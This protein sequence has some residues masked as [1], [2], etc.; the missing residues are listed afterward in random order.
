ME[1]TQ[2]STMKPWQKTKQEF[3]DKRKSTSHQTGNPSNCRNCG[4]QHPPKQCPAFGKE[5]RK[6]KKK[7]H[8]AKFCLSSTPT[9]IIKVVNK[10]DSEERY[11]IE[12]IEEINQ[13]EGNLK[14]ANVVVKIH[15]SD[16]RVALDTGAE[17]NVM[18]DRVLKKVMAN[19]K[20][21]ILK[22]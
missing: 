21:Q 17:V 2:A 1:R 8:W 11:V 15:G 13:A 10:E 4:R 5:C 9:R 3:G 16:I 22:I 18:P 6:C 12:A 7:N 20:T 14:E 19:N